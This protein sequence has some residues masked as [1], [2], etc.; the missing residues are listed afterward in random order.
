[1][2]T[3]DGLQK[4]LDNVKKTIGKHGHAV[5][6][7]ETQDGL[8]F[9]YTIGLSADGKLPEL[10]IFGLRAEIAL[11][12]L[13]NGADLLRRAGVP[14]DGIDVR[15]LFEGLPARFQTADDRAHDFTRM[16]SAWHG[17]DGYRVAQIV[18]PDRAGRFPDHPAFDP[19]LFNQQPRLWIPLVQH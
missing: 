5:I 17:H 1:M 15:E 6:G 13:N 4:V 10:L 14:A 8:P 19:K 11:T 12:V 7:T 3:R 9:S 18:W 2:A 16:A